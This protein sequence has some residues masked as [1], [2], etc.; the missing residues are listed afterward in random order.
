MPLTVHILPWHQNKHFH[1]NGN[2]FEFTWVFIN[3]SFAG[4]DMSLLISA[5]SGLATNSLECPDF[6]HNVQDILEDDLEWF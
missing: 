3:S 4:M 6:I 2:R 1:T 5:A